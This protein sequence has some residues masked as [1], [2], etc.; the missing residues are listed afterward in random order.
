MLKKTR[1]SDMRKAT[2]E[3]TTVFD[4][5]SEAVGDNFE[6]TIMPSDVDSDEP[7]P[8]VYLIESNNML[9]TVCDAVNNLMFGGEI[10]PY[11]WLAWVTQLTVTSASSSD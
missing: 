8:A 4:L 9:G 7:L 3:N 10:P 11:C 1:N 6:I 2:I 5:P